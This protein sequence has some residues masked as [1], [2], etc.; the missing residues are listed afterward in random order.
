MI[1]YLASPNSQQQA[2]HVSGMPVLLSF[3]CYSPWL[4]RYQQSFRRILIDSGA[5]SEMNTGIK[6]DLAEYR[7]WAAR[8][9]GHADA[10]AG[11]DDINGDWR[12]SLANYEA[13]PTGFPTYH[14]TDPPELLDELIPMAR[15]RGGW[16]GLGLKPPRHGK[17]SWVR[18][19]CERIPDD[20][21]VHGWALRAYTQ[22]RRL[23]SVDSTNWWRDAMKYRSELPW[24]TYGEALDIACKRYERWNRI[25]S[26]AGASDNHELFPM[27]GAA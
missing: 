20:I 6:V 5:F 14:D 3:A 19:A 8:W 9:E 16:I 25:I 2:E 26:E 11:L 10:V 7:D 4:D 22:V 27:G 15:E 21:H 17:E 12:R 18:A 1:V 13:M 24:L 23:D